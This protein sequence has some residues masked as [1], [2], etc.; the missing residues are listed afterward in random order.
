[1]LTM[2]AKLDLILFTCLCLVIRPF[3]KDSFMQWLFSYITVQNISLVVIIMSF[4]CSRFLP[5]P[6]YANIVLRF[7]FFLF[8]IYL[9]KV[10]LRPLYQEVVEHWTVFFYVAVT[11]FFSFAY[12]IFISDDIMVTLS[13]DMVPFLFLVAISVAAYASVIHTMRTMLLEAGQRERVLKGE[14]LQKLLKISTQMMGERI[15]S[16]EELVVMGRRESHD[17]RHFNH[18]ILELLRQGNEKE[19]ISLLERQDEALPME[20]IFCKNTTVNASITY[21]ARICEKKNIE[22]STSLDIP[23]NIMAD[24]VELSFAISNLLENALHAMM[25]MLN[26]EKRFIS[27]KAVYNE[28]LFLSLK[29]AYEGNVVFDENGYPFS[30]EEG[31]GLGTQ[32][33]LSFVEKQNGT[34]EYTAKNGVFEVRM[35][36]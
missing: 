29:N 8:F 17:R 3:F 11:I 16:Q 13:E 18:T 10:K 32:N 28:V 9:L 21:Y 1:N 31:H 15:K 7:L 26:K 20:K 30:H 2:L 5:M 33:V 36:V 23:E 14:S 34:V 25:G 19:A 24:D 6:V 22:F 35:Q 12:Y 27:F 4:V